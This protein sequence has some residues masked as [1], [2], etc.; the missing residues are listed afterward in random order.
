MLYTLDLHAVQLQLRAEHFT[1]IRFTVEDLYA[2]H[3]QNFAA[4]K[5]TKL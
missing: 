2:V 5:L 4:K 1:S 3:F